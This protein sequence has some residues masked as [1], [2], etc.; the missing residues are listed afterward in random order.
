MGAET[1]FEVGRLYQPIRAIS[2]ILTSSAGEIFIGLPGIEGYYP[3]SIVNGSGQAINHTGAGDPLTQAGVVPVGFDGNAY[4]QLGSGVNYLLRASAYG[5]T[6]TE[7]FISS[8]VRGFTLGGWFSIN[9]LPATSGGFISR[10]GATGQRGYSLIVLSTGVVRMAMSG[11]G[12]AVLFV[13]S[14][15]VPLNE[16]LFLVARYIPSTELSVFVNGVKTVN[17][18]S[19]PASCFVSSQQF[20]VGRYINSDTR[21]VDAK[22]R[23]VFI[24]RSALTDAQIAAIRTAT[25]P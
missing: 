7:T 23:D 5:L 10:E 14:A 9:S 17:T 1:A 18:T 2:D 20:E 13:D 21:V 6:G 3:M 16:W 4:R 12:T 19:I 11:D 15:A 24:C 22:A 8:S 25:A